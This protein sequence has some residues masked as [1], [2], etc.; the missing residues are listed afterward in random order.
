[1]DTGDNNNDCD[2]NGGNV[3]DLVAIFGIAFMG[4]EFFTDYDNYAGNSINETVCGVGDYDY[5]IRNK[6]NDNFEAGEKKVN[7]NIY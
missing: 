2:N 3:F 6:T 5:R 7:K 4:G 1:M